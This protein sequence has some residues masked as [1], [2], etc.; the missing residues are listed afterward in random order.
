MPQ[1]TLCFVLALLMNQAFSQESASLAT[2][3]N[4]AE[5]HDHLFPEEMEYWKDAQ[6]ELLQGIV[7]AE[8]LRAKLLSTGPDG[9][10]YADVVAEAM[11]RFQAGCKAKLEDG[12]SVDDFDMSDIRLAKQIRGKE[13]IPL[14]A[15]KAFDGRWFGRWGDSEVNHDWRPSVPF[16][17]PKHLIADQPAV[18]SLQYAWI[19]G[20]FGWNYLMSTDEKNR[21]NFVLGMV[22]YFGDDLKLITGTKAHVGFADS[23]TRLVWITEYEVF[24]EE[25]FPATDAH[26]EQYAITA[27]YHN[28]F[29]DTPSVS[30]HGTQAIYTRDPKHRPLF[31][32]FDWR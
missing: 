8:K 4:S 5:N 29:T 2:S 31:K 11:A 9:R 17:P 25:V 1:K 3:K 10:V 30:P 12:V 21:G 24:L 27:L 18:A 26:A 15:F 6:T 20:G 22:Y 7:E 13:S 14:D 32:K 19:S 23:P 16:T 28:L